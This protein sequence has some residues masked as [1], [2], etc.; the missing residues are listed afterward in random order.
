MKTCFDRNVKTLELKATEVSMEIVMLSNPGNIVLFLKI[1][2]DL[3][4]SR[5]FGNINEGLF[6]SKTYFARFQSTR[7]LTKSTGIMNGFSS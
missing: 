5:S 3:P 2:V 7:K 4:L 1:I 6:T